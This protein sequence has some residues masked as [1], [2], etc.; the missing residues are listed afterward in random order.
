MLEREHPNLKIEVRPNLSSEYI[1]TPKD[2][3]SVALLRILLDL[4]VRRRKVV[5]ER[6]PTNLPLEAVE[7]HPHVISTKRLRTGR[8]NTATRQV[9]LVHVGQPPDKLDP[10]NW[11]CYT[12]HPYQGGPVRCYNATASTTSRQRVSTPSDAVCAVRPIRWRSASSAT[13]SVRSSPQSAPT[14]AKGTTRGTHN[15]LSDTGECCFPAGTNSTSSSNQ[16][17]A[18]SN[19]SSNNNVDVLSSSSGPVD[20]LINSSSSSRSHVLTPSNRGTVPFRATTS[21]AGVGQPPNPQGPAAQVKEDEQTAV[22]GEVSTTNNTANPPD[23]AHIPLSPLPL[24][25]REE[26]NRCTPKRAHPRDDPPNNTPT[27]QSTAPLLDRSRPSPSLGNT[28]L[29]EE[30]TTFVNAILVRLLVQVI[31]R[32]IQ[33]LEHTPFRESDLNVLH[34]NELLTAVTGGACQPAPPST[35]RENSQHSL[36]AVEDHSIQQP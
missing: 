24:P 7:A 34:H 10:G 18:L 25:Q 23:Q 8:D 4:K 1:L 5:M 30:T 6:Y 11:G 9:L 36:H 19:T 20:A 35:R 32:L 27:A 31:K 2:E 15:A 33:R 21:P 29:S 3:E 12:L 13:K 14:A 22:R 17:D 28:N 26:R 16:V